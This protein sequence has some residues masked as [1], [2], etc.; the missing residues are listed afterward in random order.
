METTDL[1][2]ISNLE[3]AA[4]LSLWV[5]FGGQI[6]MGAHNGRKDQLTT[7]GIFRAALAGREI[8]LNWRQMDAAVS[9]IAVFQWGLYIYHYQGRCRGKNFLLG[10]GDF[11]RLGFSLHPFPNTSLLGSEGVQ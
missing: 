3:T 5:R 1:L 9:N 7:H 6:W 2:E 11:P 8:R 10:P 4:T